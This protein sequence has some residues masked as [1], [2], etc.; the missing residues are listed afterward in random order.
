MKILYVDLQYEY[1]MKHRGP[2]SIGEIGFRQVFVKLGHEVECFYY[3]DYLSRTDE[4]QDAVIAKVKE[5]KPDLVFFCLFADQF[6]IS[7]LETIAK[8]TK[9]MNWFGDDQWRFDNFTSKYAKAFTYCITTDYF[10]IPKYKSLGVTN[11]IY[12]Q[13][14]AL[15]VPIEDNPVTMNYEYDISFIGGSHSVRRWFIA[16]FKKAGLNVEAFGFG[17]PNGVVP[18]ER[19]VQIFQRSKINLNL[20]NSVNFDL[21][22]LTHAW[23]NPVVAFKS[24]KATS[25]IKARNFEIPFYGGFQLTDYVPTLENYFTL[26]QELVCYSNVD[27]AIQLA[28]HYL[29]N[30]LDRERVKAAG[31][32]RA[33]EQHTYLHR[34]EKV[35]SQL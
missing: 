8:L 30:D 32:L 19:M 5:S 20:S 15:N 34:M 6:K 21:R 25:Q 33:R 4:L 31:I 28:Q 13:W 27:E 22:Y 12:S 17:W 10:S 7:T 26:G 16:E 35:L 24:S 9:T 3:D 18:L 11:V 14:A 1:G 2:N 23:K 29:T